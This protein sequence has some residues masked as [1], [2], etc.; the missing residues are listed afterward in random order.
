MALLQNEEFAIWYLRTSFLASVKDGIA[1]RLVS[2]NNSVLNSPGFRAA[3]WSA[4]PVQ[5]TYSPPIP[6]SINTDYFQNGAD[7]Q[8]LNSQGD[9]EEEGGLV[10]GRVSNDTI[11]PAF[12]ARRRRRK[13]HVED[14]DSSD[15]TDES[16]EE[17]E[18]AQRAAQ[19]IRFA[20]MPARNR[21]DSSPIRSTGPD[22][23]TTSPSKPTTNNR[24]RTG[25][26]GA[27]EAVKARAR[28]DTATSSDLSSENE[29]DPAYF[30]RR[31]LN[32]SRTSKSAPLSKNDI[33]RS[34]QGQAQDDSD[35]ESVG[36]AM[37]SELGE[38]IDSASLLNTMEV[39]N[40]TS[41]PPSL[42]SLTASGSSAP[43]LPHAESPRRQ[44]TLPI[45]HEL[46][47][48]R[49]ISFIQP[50]S[51]LS[52]ALNAEKK[53]PSNPLQTFAGLSGKGNPNPLWIKIYVP[54]SN[55]PDEPLEMP[56]ARTSKDGNP[57]SVAEAIGLSLWRYQEEEL[58]PALTPAQLDVNKWTL[59][60][61]EDGEVDDDFPPLV[62]TRP[63]TD[64]TYNNNRGGR[65][66]SRDRPFDEFALVEASP[67]QFEA[68]K[69]DT[70]Q[71]AAATEREVV[72]APAAEP[73]ISQ[74]QPPGPPKQTQSSRNL[75]LAGQPF[76]SAL[77]NTS[78]TPADMPAPS[79]PSATPR[80]GTTKTIRVRYFDIDV[81][82][83]TMTMEVSI[84]SYIAEILDHVCRRWN[85]E[86]AGFVLKVAGTNTVAPLDR[87]VEAL[88]PRSDLDLV[89]RRFGASVPTLTGS[90]GSSSPNA[91]LLLDIQGPKKT[92]KGQLHHPLA[93]K[94]DLL[95][96]ASNFKKY[97]VIRKQLA[98]FAQGS[99]RTLVFDGDLLHVMPTDP[100][101]NAK[102]TSF[103]FS[104][105]LRCKVS[106]K[107]SKLFRVWV[108]RV[109]ENKRYDFEA[110][111]AA[112]AQEIVDEIAREMRQTRA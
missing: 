60:M 50:R 42:G 108:R 17:A 4:D 110:R 100:A 8:L 6:T 11:G 89:R 111:T 7:L 103:P 101:T 99:Q 28:A 59:R 75:L 81:A 27:V 62:R 67:A 69:K 35:V 12:N 104:D 10:T 78:L 79:A 84:D 39:P 2:V 5:R 73:T 14:D 76:A 49:P 48:P 33:L 44:R 77:A 68:N 58:E 85:F 112:E 94:Q 64:F 9:E 55:E 74:S 80:M 86:K 45:L 54:W 57:V 61:I 97:Y 22:I 83:Q 91:P 96:S 20:K 34:G 41:S 88:G 90:P 70:P 32:A 106:T 16:E 65:G 23:I 19:Q 31:Q 52:A 21:A 63:I 92:K 109:N 46:P 13:E 43:R 72:P 36:S 95:S 38:T 56:L 105:I 71:Y 98:P 66:R 82:A 26:L 25:S 107:H 24:R 51:L 87:T 47:P 93:Q 53:A 40:L 3:G 18:G 15:L 1:E 30:Q 29:V 37:S 102:F